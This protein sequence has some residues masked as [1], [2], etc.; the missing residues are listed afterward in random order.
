[1]IEIFIIGGAIVALMV[2]VSTRIKRSAAQAFE[3]EIIETEEFRIVKP[4]GF[5]HPLRENS[6][7][8]FEA[9]SKD[10]GD[11]EL[12]NYWQ[13]NAELLIHS[14]KK[15]KDV[16]ADAKKDDDEILSEKI[17]KDAPADQRI[18]LI[19]GEQIGDEA[20][21]RIFRKI[22]ESLSQKK[23]YELRIYVLSNHLSDQSAKTEEMLEGFTVK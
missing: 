12:R 7:F 9:Y 1:M 16:C 5:M 10:Y 8:A 18:C 11:G 15:F 14:N 19:E 17:L 21:K 4:E 13:S 2:Y 3:A 22:V 20:K 6:E 23:V